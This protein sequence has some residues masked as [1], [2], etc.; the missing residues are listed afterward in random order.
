M[1][2]TNFTVHFSTLPGDRFL[3]VSEL[4]RVKF[5]FLHLIHLLVAL[6]LLVALLDLKLFLPYMYS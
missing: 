4:S 2:P 5:L 3:G 1:A 6:Y